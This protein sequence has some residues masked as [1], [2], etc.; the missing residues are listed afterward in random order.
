M[1]A[2]ISA[3]LFHCNSLFP[4][5]LRSPVSD[6]NNPSSHEKMDFQV[7]GLLQGDLLKDQGWWRLLREECQLQVT[8]DPVDHDRR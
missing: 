5:G 2:A 3:H 8:D 6:G 4:L 7:F 1:M